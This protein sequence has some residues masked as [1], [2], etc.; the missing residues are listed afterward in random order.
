MRLSRWIP[1]VSESCWQATAFDQRL[2]D[3]GK[4]RRLQTAKTLGE[5]TE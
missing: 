4:P 1:T 2:E 5:R 3:G